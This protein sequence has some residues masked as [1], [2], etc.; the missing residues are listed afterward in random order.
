MSEDKELIKVNKISDTLFYAVKKYLD[1]NFEDKDYEE[2]SCKKVNFGFRASRRRRVFASETCRFC[3]L[4]EIEEGE[5]LDSMLE[6]MDESFTV[7]LLKLI[8]LKGITDV[9]CYKK[10]NVSKQTWY[11]IINEKDYKPSKNTVISFAIALE[12]SLDETKHLLSTV[13]FTLSRSSK[14]DIIIEYFITNGVYDI[15]TINET[16]FAFDQVCLGV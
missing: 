8:D 14:F 3:L 11:K 12:L 6:K 9:E 5:S 1:D 13:G 7:T 16:L 10:A 2:I 15:F 4:G